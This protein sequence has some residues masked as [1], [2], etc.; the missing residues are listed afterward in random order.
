MGLVA[1]ADLA[2]HAPDI[3]LG[4]LL[5]AQKVLHAAGA[6]ARQLLEVPEKGMLAQHLAE[7][8][9]VFKTGMPN[10]LSLNIDTMFSYSFVC[11]VGFQSSGTHPFTSAET[12]YKMYILFHIY[13]G[14]SGC[15]QLAYNPYTKTWTN[16]YG[17]GNSWYD[18]GAY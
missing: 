8:L 7:L 2:V 14:A 16:R 10:Q 3:V 1:L 9:G 5:F 6:K 17:S 11:R 12:N 13:L 18:W 15:Y 4:L